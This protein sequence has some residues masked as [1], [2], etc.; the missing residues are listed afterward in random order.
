M[1]V[2]LERGHV[3][4]EEPGFA[5]APADRLELLDR[6]C[7]EQP[8][9]LGSMHIMPVV[10]VLDHHDADELGMPAMMREGEFRK[11]L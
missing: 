9:Q 11:S 5:A 6:T 7:I 4:A 8:D 10:D 1:P 3:I 2:K